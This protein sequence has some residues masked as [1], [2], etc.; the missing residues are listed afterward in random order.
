MTST[1]TL[2]EVG[3]P[4]QWISN[5]GHSQHID[6][7][8]EFYR[9]VEDFLLRACGQESAAPAPVGRDG[10]ATQAEPHAEPVELGSLRVLHLDGVVGKLRID[11]PSVH[12]LPCSVHEP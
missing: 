4:V 3:F 8:E 2:L 12:L 5:S 11:E 1:S 10:S 6:N 9:A 7:P